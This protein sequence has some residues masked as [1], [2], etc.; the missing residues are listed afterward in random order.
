MFCTKFFWLTKLPQTSCLFSKTSRSA[1]TKFEHLETRWRAESSALHHT[2]SS[3]INTK[4]FDEINQ[5]TMQCRITSYKCTRWKPNVPIAKQCPD[6]AQYI[7]MGITIDKISGGQRPLPM[8]CFF[9]LSYGRSR[10]KARSLHEKK[11]FKKTS[12][13]T[14]QRGK[15]S[16]PKHKPPKTKGKTQIPQP[17]FA[18]HHPKDSKA[19]SERGKS[20]TETTTK[21]L[22]RTQW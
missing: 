15:S 3:K 13:W 10:S 9:F 19:N 1:K 4:N 5:I 6:S 7:K 12:T 11:Q 2:I 8:Q 21:D 20:P 22:P 17:R 16:K 18:S 14:Q